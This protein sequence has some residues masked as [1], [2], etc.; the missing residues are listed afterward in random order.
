MLNGWK[1]NVNNASH[2]D[3]VLMGISSLKKASDTNSTLRM[4]YSV[5]AGKGGHAEAIPVEPA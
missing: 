4:H 5:D 2:I 1:H 3:A